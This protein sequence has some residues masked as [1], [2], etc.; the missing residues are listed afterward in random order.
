MNLFIDTMLKLVNEGTRIHEDYQRR[1]RSL[2]IDPNKPLKIKRSDLD[3]LP[4][5]KSISYT[6]SLFGFRVEIIE[7]YDGFICD[8]RNM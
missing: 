8:N 6:N 7:D 3:K 5:K 2:G 4:I 1:L